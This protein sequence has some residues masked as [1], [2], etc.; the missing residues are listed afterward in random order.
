AD[1][2]LHGRISTPADARASR[3]AQYFYVNRR[4]VRDKLL[5][6]AVRQAYQDVL[7]HDRHPAFVLFLEL[8]PA[9]V[10]VNVHPAKT[11]VRFRDSRGVH[12]YV[13]HALSQALAGTAGAV[14]PPPFPDNGHVAEIASV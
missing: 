3:D 10:D 1:V 2:R 7:H 12:Q 6:H 11:E 5:A 14:A 9:Q 13:F 8:D 4:F